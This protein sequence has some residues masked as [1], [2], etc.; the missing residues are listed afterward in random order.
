M[1][2][3]IAMLLALLLVA[4]MLPVTAMAVEVVETAE[5]FENA[6]AAGAEITLNHDIDLTKTI[7]IST[8]GKVTIDLNGYAI[9]NP[10]G[11]ALM[12][13]KGALTI[14]GTGTVEDTNQKGAGICVRGSN[15]SEDS[16]YSVLTVDKNVTLK[17]IYGFFVTPY[18][19]GVQQVAYGVQINFNGKTDSAGGAYINGQ[20]QHKNNCPVINIGS[21]ADLQ[22]SG[23]GIYAAGYG[24]WNIQGSI[25][26]PTG[27]YSKAG[28][29]NLNGATVK[30]TGEK[31][32]P[33][34]NGNGCNSTGDAIILDS[35]ENYAGDMKLNVGAGTVLTSTNGYAL[36]MAN[37]DVADPETNVVDLTISGGNFTGNENL[38]ALKFS[39]G[40]IDKANVSNTG[41]TAKVTGGT[42]NFVPETD[43]GA[44]AKGDLEALVPENMVLDLNGND[45]TVKPKN[46]TIVIIQPTEE[47]PAEDQ[48][49]PS[50]G[51]ND[52]VGIVAAMAIVSVV[53]AAVVSRKK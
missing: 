1:R 32:E 28:I 49:N 5:E 51:A 52:F 20:I 39:K 38:G 44:K 23:V 14:T 42:Y 11:T 50:T 36:Q 31:A 19:S 41:V 35:K 40:F 10:N 43:E 26:G 24:I 47:K 12:L 27:I 3:T 2:K 48:K 4:V 8:D 21:S 16:N 33:V 6:V 46:T 22:G 30:G 15:N 17:G 37:T 29:I 53:G 13:S 18:E 9:K 25:T 45:G 7:V 34:A